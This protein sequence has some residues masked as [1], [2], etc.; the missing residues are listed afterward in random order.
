MGIVE[1]PH[2][3]NRRRNRFKK[4]RKIS[5]VRQPVQVDDI[6]VNFPPIQNRRLGQ[7]AHRIRFAF[8][9]SAGKVF[10]ELPVDPTLTT[11][12]K[13]FLHKTKR[14]LVAIRRKFNLFERFVQRHVLFVTKVVKTTIDT[15]SQQS[16][17]LPFRSSGRATMRKS[18]K[19][20]YLHASSF[21]MLLNSL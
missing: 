8:R 16:V 17:M 7:F 13:I 12:G 15:G 18:A 20:S 14:W 6:G 21:L 5:E 1:R 3:W 10:I 11:F 9:S 2:D 4:R 19:V